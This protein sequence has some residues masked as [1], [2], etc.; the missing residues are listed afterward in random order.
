MEPAGTRTGRGLEERPVEC[1]TAIPGSATPQIAPDCGTPP[2]GRGRPRSRSAV[3]S[4]RPAA[5]PLAG[6]SRLSGRFCA[7]RSAQRHDVPPR[8]KVESPSIRRWRSR[9]ETMCPGCTT[10]RI[11]LADRKRFGCLVAP[12]RSGH[13]NGRCERVQP[14][15]R[16]LD[17]IRAIRSAFAACEPALVE[18]GSTR[19]QANAAA[20]A[21]ALI[22]SE[23]SRG[24]RE[25]PPMPRSPGSGT[26]QPP[27][28]AGNG[29]NEI[30]SSN[31][32]WL[33]SPCCAA[34]LA[35]PARAPMKPRL[36]TE[37]SPA[38][39]AVF[40]SPR[41]TSRPSEGR[42]VSVVSCTCSTQ[43]SAAKVS[44]RLPRRDDVPVPPRPPR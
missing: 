19:H 37:R 8:D 27:D 20:R 17:P 43:P 5:A 15:R 32:R 22:T 34:N 11:Q 3:G 36:E 29:S 18:S 26:P 38:A 13:F 21:P 31:A 30:R 25:L 7:F 44:R 1:S 35:Q 28:P 4:I 24:R 10:T 14:P 16:A 33:E 9:T 42:S 40:S 41:W 2:R 23:R 39:I 6:S 12:V